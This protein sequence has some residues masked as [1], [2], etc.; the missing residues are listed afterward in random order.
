MTGAVEFWALFIAL[1]RA[2]DVHVVIVI[3]AYGAPVEV[4][5]SLGLYA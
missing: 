2:L 4:T 3:N 1:D 5:Q